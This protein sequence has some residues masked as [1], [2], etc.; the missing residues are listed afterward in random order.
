MISKINEPFLLGSSAVLSLAFLM[1]ALPASAQSVDLSDPQ[2]IESYTD[3]NAPQKTT[4]SLS[5]L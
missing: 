3:L 4:A 2:S 1:I 5:E